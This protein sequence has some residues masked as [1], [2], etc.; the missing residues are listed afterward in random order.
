MLRSVRLEEVGHLY[1]KDKDNQS[2]VQFSASFKSENL[3]SLLLRV[4]LSLKSGRWDS[5]PRHS[6][7][8]GDALPL[9]Y[10]RINAA[11]C[12]ADR[13]GLLCT[14]AIIANLVEYVNSFFQSVLW[15]QIGS[16]R[17][18]ILALIS[19]FLINKTIGI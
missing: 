10:A 19:S 15:N 13:L 7:W 2:L 8:Q 6:P 17:N 1:G 11:L 14:R 12:L 5:N 16:S 4:Y 3:L 18:T 9:S